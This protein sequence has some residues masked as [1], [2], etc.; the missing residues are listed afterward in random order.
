MAQTAIDFSQDF[1]TWI[2]GDGANIN[3]FN[4]DV[5]GSGDPDPWT[6]ANLVNSY[7]V[8]A[9]GVHRG[10]ACSFKGRAA[11]SSGAIADISVAEGQ[12]VGRR[13]NVLG[14]FALALADL[15]SGGART[16]LGRAANS[17]GA[18]ADIA[19]AGTATVPQIMMD[20]G[21]AL[22]FAS[23]ASVRATASV[24]YEVNFSTL[25]NNTLVDGAETIDGLSY[26]AANMAELGT[27]A[28][29]NATG[30]RMIAATSNGG[31]STMT[32]ASQTAAHIYVPLSQL[33]GYD[34]TGD[35]IVE[36]Y[37]PSLVLE[38]SGESVFIGIWG[39]ATSPYAGST[40]R[41]RKATIVNNA[42]TR[43]LRATVNATDAS[44]DLAIPTH[45]VLAFRVGPS[46]IGQVYSG[47]W[48]SGWPTLTAGPTHATLAAGADPMNT[49]DVRLFLGLGTANDASP[50]TAVTFERMRIRRVA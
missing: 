24:L 39:V 32:S 12:F 18:R 33:A 49:G 44:S 40:A 48:S 23:F 10:T 20:D 1:A 41:M 2:A 6:W 15:P 3:E 50:T 28:V 9:Y 31:A 29:Q 19:G 43:I 21:S 30:I 45:N 38:A 14:S 25:A 47:V 5:S 4:I 46:G 22:A 11:N 34:P 8:A 27:A 26:V 36:V 42:G 17:S 16:L 35:Y 7:I 37:M 13:S